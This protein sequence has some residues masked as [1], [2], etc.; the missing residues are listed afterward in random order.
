MRKIEAKKSLRE[1]LPPVRLDLDDL[2]RIEAILGKQPSYS[3]WIPGFEFENVADLVKHQEG[4]TLKNVHFGGRGAVRLHIGERFLN[5][6]DVQLEVS[7][8]DDP[9]SA[10]A[11][12]HIKEVLKPRERKRLPK[13]AYRASIPLMLVV[14]WFT[15]GWQV[16]SLLKMHPV[17]R[18]VI[19][20]PLFGWS[21]FALYASRLESLI[22]VG[23]KTDKPGFFERRRE[24]LA[25]EALK[26][27]GTAIAGGVVGWL[28]K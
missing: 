25:F 21:L 20:L 6:D 4:K 14:V 22:L 8:I 10:G 18:P 3:I 17:V 5:S 19:L 13:I 2:E 26:L 11:V 28:L 9:V 1:A 27:S 15:I 24:D 23:R 12:F 7:D 16:T